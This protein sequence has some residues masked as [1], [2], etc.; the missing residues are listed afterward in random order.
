MVFYLLGLTLLWALYVS[1][2]RGLLARKQ[3]KEMVNT[4]NTAVTTIPAHDQEFDYKKNFENKRY[5][6]VICIPFWHYR[7]FRSVK[8]PNKVHSLSCTQPGSQYWC[9]KCLWTLAPTSEFYILPWSSLAFHGDDYTFSV[10]FFLASATLLSTFL[11][12]I[13]S[14]LC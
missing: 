9:I 1:A 7:V 14:V 13:L 12:L 5:I 2:A 4:K 10:F 3:R 11:P 8:L 6:T